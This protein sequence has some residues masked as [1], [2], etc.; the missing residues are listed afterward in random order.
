MILLVLLFPASFAFANP[1][2]LPD[3]GDI[4]LVVVLGLTFAAEASIITLIL[5]FC[6]LAIVPSV[7]AMFAGNLL[8]YFVIFRPV[9]EAT[10][11][12][13]IAEAVIVA[14]EAVFILIISRIELFQDEDFKGLK[15]R[16]AFLCAVVGN[17]LSYY[18]GTVIVA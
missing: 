6:H 15:W 10:N 1:I 4:K 12:V 17:L 2:F 7:I 3:V 9:L 8:M 11:N 18:V 5:F 16:T 13:P 14:A